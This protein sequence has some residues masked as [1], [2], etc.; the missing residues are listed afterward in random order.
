MLSFLDRFPLPLLIF[1][2]VLMAAAPFYP[3]PHLWQKLKMLFSGTLTQP[4]D[5]FDL[6]FHSA[7]LLLVGLK[8]VRMRA[9]E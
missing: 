5:V 8:L 9:E 4:I 2:A 3:E 7:G 1:L 6:F